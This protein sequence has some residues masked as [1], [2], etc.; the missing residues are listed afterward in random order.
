MPIKVAAAPE[1]ALK[2]LRAGIENYLSSG[3]ADPKLIDAKVVDRKL[4]QITGYAALHRVFYLSLDGLVGGKPIA[5]VAKLVG[6]RAELLDSDN[7]TVA[8]ADLVI[9]RTGLEFANVS[10]GPRAVNSGDAKKVAEDWSKSKA[11]QELAF[12]NIPGI[13]CTLFWLRGND[14]TPDAFV[15]IPPCPKNIEPGRVYDEDE[16]RAALEPLARKQL[17]FVPAAAKRR[18]RRPAV[19]RSSRRRRPKRAKTRR[20]SRRRR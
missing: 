15:P 9:K 19:K 4:G 16:L 14:G 11:D 10:Y 7:Q 3:L 5:K 1:S 20:Q 17:A 6:W 2:L 12:L 18:S 8:A 13:Y